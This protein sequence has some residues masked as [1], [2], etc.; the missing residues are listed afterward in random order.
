MTAMK[1][2]PL[3]NKVAFVSGGSRGLGR[4]MSMGLAEAGAHVIVGARDVQA[5]EETVD[6]IRDQGR[7]CHAVVLDVTSMENV[8]SALREAGREAGKPVDILVNNAGISTANTK[9]EDLPE[10]D[11]RT[12]LDVNLN[13][14]FRMG[15]AAAQDMIRQRSGKIV[16]ISSVL[17]ETPAPL[18]S[19]YS[20]SKAAINQLTRAWAVE[21]AR[22]NIQVN[23]VAPA[24]VE[25]E[26]TKSQLQ[27]PG[28]RQKLL[29]R[30]PAGRLG[31]PEDLIGAL[32]FLASAASDYVTGVILPVDGG[33]SAA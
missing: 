28:F 18:A 25:T 3:E 7:R 21:W 15:L 20:V 9:A 26:L 19:A 5:L 14:Y 31:R 32:V 8:R 11:W 24:F 10:K 12:V 27:D 1:T 16:N 33:W 23:A 13:G 29:S 17:G 6:H 4:A 30:I 22:Y 2:M